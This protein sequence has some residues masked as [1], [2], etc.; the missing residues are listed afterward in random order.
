MESAAILPQRASAVGDFL[1]SSSLGAILD[2]G[3]RYVCRLCDATNSTSAV[4]CAQAFQWLVLIE[5]P[6]AL[7][8]NDALRLARELLVWA[9]QP[10]SR[11]E[12]E[13][14]TPTAGDARAR[15]AT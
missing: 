12:C 8:A 13:A 11:F 4:E 3:G 14:T 9:E 2:R 5:H 6:N 1:H 10:P 15:E 7:P